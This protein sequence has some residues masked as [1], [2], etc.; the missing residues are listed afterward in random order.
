MPENCKVISNPPYADIADYGYN[1]NISEVLTNTKEYY[2]AFMEKIVSQSK[3]S[4]IITP[5]SFIGGTKFYSLRKILNNYNRW[6][7]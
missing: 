2:A 6:L 4:V 3:G 1:W 5:Y 7:F